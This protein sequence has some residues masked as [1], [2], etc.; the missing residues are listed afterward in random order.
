MV[1]DEENA[2]PEA[3]GGP[4]T[5]SKGVNSINDCDKWRQDIIKEICDKVSEIQNAGLG[6]HKIRSL[7]DEINQLLDEK[8]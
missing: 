2:L 7:N 8:R 1:A 3:A 4:A 5:S 6:E